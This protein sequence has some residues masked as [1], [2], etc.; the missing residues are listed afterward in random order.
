MKLLQEIEQPPIVYENTVEFARLQDFSD[1]L[2]NFRSRFFI[3]RHKQKETVYF[4]GNSLG[5]QPKSTLEY[6]N[7]ELEDWEEFGVEGH[8][9]ARNPWV[10]YHEQ[11]A[12]PVAKIIGA[13]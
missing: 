1:P 2:K 5:L 4:T 8:F 9:K 10:S 7:R 11:F 6:I 12:K 13:E 3:P